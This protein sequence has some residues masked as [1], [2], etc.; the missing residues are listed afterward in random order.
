MIL[1]TVGTQFGFDRLIR[2]MDEWCRTNPGQDVLAQIGSGE[3]IPENMKWQRD[4]GPTEFSR[5]LDTAMLVISHAGM[6]TIISSL[7]SEKP[8]VIVPRLGS[9]GEH[10]NDH[11]VAT[12]KKFAGRRGIYVVTA[13]EE[14]SSMIKAA[15][16]EPYKSEIDKELEQ[17]M[18]RLSVE[19][20]PP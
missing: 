20:G 12:T 2:W 19:I 16:S 18:Q 3:Y 5:A 11:Q 10:R 14:L 8:I 15:A 9:L 13:Q 1:V 17:L 4:I 7:L 6:G